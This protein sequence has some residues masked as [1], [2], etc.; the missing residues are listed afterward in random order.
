MI[1]EI[2]QHHREFREEKELRKVGAMNNNAFTLLV[3]K[4]KGKKARRQELSYVYDQPCRGYRDLYSKWHDNS[5]FS[6]LRG[7]SGKNS[8]ATRNFRA[9]L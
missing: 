7:A 4:S 9:G 5:E 1:Q 3:G 6:F 8:L 2:W